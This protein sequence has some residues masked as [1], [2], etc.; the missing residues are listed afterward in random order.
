MGLSVKTDG[1]ATASGSVLSGLLGLGPSG[2]PATMAATTKVLIDLWIGLIAFT[3]SLV[4]TYRID[5]KP[6][7]RVSPM[8]IWYRFPKF[9]LGY[10]F[11][12]L[13][14]SAIAFTYPTVAAGAKA[15]PP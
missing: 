6:G 1:A 15:V 10:F 5:K 8:I 2:V 11:T 7:A 12:S 13:V 4:F 9:V 14:L 3:L